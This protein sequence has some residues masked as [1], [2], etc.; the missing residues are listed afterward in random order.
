MPSKEIEGIDF[1]YKL[2]EVLDSVSPNQKFSAKQLEGYLIKKGVSP[3]ELKQSE[4]FNSVDTK[5]LKVSEWLDKLTLSGNKHKVNTITKRQYSDITLGEKGV[6]NRT[7]KETLTTVNKPKENAP[8]M[9]HFDSAVDTMNMP[10]S[11]IGDFKPTDTKEVR[12]LKEELDMIDSR[13]SEIFESFTDHSDVIGNRE[14]M[15]LG[16]QIDTIQAK[17]DILTNPSRMPNQTLL[18]WRRT[19]TDSI[20]G[21]DTTVLNE[22]QSDWAQTERAGRGQFKSTIEDIKATKYELQKEYDALDKKIKYYN[23]KALKQNNENGEILYEPGELEAYKRF[24]K[25]YNELNSAKLAIKDKIVADF[26]MS[27]QKHH[28]FQIVGA[29]DE[30]IKTGTNRVAIP[31][32]RQNELAGSAGVTK[33][34]DSLNKKILPEIRKKLDKQGLKI[35]VSKEDYLDEGTFIAD[36]RSSI[37]DNI[38]DNYG[39]DWFSKNSFIIDADISDVLKGKKPETSAVKD[40]LEF[41]GSDIKEGGGKN[42]LHVLEIVSKPSIRVKWDV[43]SMLGAIGLGELGNKLK[44]NNE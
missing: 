10:S 23:T 7:Y 31:I 11:S 27:E 20:N 41:L 37:Q 14:F 4:L 1:T 28:Q 9:P 13:R 19:H 2:N 42:T 44:E 34:Y 30:A 21:K 40:A 29:I 36:A 35:K 3:K 22:F 16:T 33:F 43:Y 18:G 15:N 17:L 26:P 39:S 8:D 5:A 32:Q 12:A 38:L 25:L 24:D 6:D